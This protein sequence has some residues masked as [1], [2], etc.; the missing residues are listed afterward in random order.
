MVGPSVYADAGAGNRAKLVFPSLFRI[1][2]GVR[3]VR[4]DR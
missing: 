3:H 4:R 1:C 2:Q